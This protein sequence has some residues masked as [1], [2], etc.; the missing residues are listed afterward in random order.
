MFFDLLVHIR[1]TI[2]EVTGR[3]SITKDRIFVLQEPRI[4][5]SY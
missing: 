3:D 2:N 1:H 5:R 4:H